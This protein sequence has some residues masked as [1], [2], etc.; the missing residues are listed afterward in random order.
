MSVA[1]AAHIGYAVEKRGEGDAKESLGIW[2]VC[3]D[4]I[5][6]APCVGGLLAP[7]EWP[8]H[9]NSR[10]FFSPSCKGAAD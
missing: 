1:V 2:F 6:V 4:Y 5:F 7:T 10:K 3:S 9:L 8:S